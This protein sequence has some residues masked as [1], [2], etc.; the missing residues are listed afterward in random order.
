MPEKIQVLEKAV[1]DAIDLISSLE[2]EKSGLQK[3]LLSQTATKSPP[4][5]QR[6]GSDARLAALKEENRLLKEQQRATRS[7]IKQIMRKIDRMT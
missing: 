7:R 5:P 6:G 3:K 4:S 2:K 1:Y